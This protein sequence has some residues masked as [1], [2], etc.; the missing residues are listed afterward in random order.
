VARPTDAP[1]L[2]QLVPSHVAREVDHRIYAYLRR[3]GEHGV[4]MR[5][6]SEVESRLGWTAE[7]CVRYA[8][9]GLQGTKSWKRIS[10]AKSAIVDL[11]FLWDS[12][13]TAKSSIDDFD[14]GDPV[15]LTVVAASAR[16][17]LSEDYGLT[18]RQLGALAGVDPSTVRQLGL[19]LRGVRP[20]KLLAKYARRWLIERGIPGFESGA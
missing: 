4:L 2:H 19:P 5:R 12:P 11:L 16:V 9:G 1:R 6:V 10:N 14:L 18:A 20:A 13:S 8:Q 7:E 17:E 3:G 15:A